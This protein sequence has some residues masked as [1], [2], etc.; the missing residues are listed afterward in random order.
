MNIIPADLEENLMMP[1]FMQTL[2]LTLKSRTNRERSKLEYFSIIFIQ[3]KVDKSFFL[4]A[5][6]Q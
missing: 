3:F 2:F 6:N 4:L 5:K 1:D